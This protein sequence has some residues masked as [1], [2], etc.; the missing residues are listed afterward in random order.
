MK[1]A[2]LALWLEYRIHLVDFGRAFGRIW[3]RQEYYHPD[4]CH[5][6][7][8]VN[9]CGFF[10]KTAW[11]CVGLIDDWTPDHFLCLRIADRPRRQL[12]L[13]A[14]HD[15]TSIIHRPKRSIHRA[16][17]ANGDLGRV[18]LH[19]I[20][21]VAALDDGQSLTYSRIDL[22]VLFVLRFRVQDLQ[23]Q[24]RFSAESEAV[25]TRGVM[26]VLRDL[27]ADPRK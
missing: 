23:P 1:G 14:L 8:E 5:L 19:P 27:I 9:A 17:L 15:V 21:S 25:D 3:K 20:V 11:S 7:P 12:P 24:D 26:G 6:F 22:V 2:L 10:G 4:L 13:V 16:F 18:R